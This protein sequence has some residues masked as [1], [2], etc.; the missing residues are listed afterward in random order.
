MQH[1]QNILEEDRQV[2]VNNIG[3][4]YAYLDMHLDSM[5][6]EEAVLWQTLLKELDPN[7]ENQEQL[8]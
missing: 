8:E 2:L 5:T 1:L 3:T 7:F 6:G 4:L